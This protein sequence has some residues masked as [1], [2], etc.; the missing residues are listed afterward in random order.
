V[1]KLEILAED[2]RLLADGDTE[3]RLNPAIKRRRRLSA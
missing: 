1:R 3:L 2:G